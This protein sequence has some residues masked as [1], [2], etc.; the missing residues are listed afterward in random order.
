MKA[1]SNGH[2]KVLFWLEYTAPLAMEL[3]PIVPKKGTQP[4]GAAIHPSVGWSLLG[5]GD[6]TPAS[7]RCQEIQ[8]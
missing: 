2:Q 8:G 1:A 6:L 5:L 4:A 3:L 7:H